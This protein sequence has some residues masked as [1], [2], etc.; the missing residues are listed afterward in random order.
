MG[1][2]F[3]L[4]SV[5]EIPRRLALDFGDF[6][7]TGMSF[8]SINGEFALVG[9]NANTSNLHIASPAADI[10]IRGRT[11]L[12]ARD[13]DQQ[14]VV[15][16]RVGGAL[17]VVGA[18]AG[19]PAGA[20]AGLAVQTLFNKAINQVT[21]ARY[22]VTGSWEKPD[23]TLISREGGRTRPS[24]TPPAANDAGELHGPPVEAPAPQP[25]NE[26]R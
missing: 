7:R 20:A 6:F 25:G 26:R 2:L 5:R 23:I 22:H 21:T 4:F 13:Y 19:G 16:P 3:G 10:R 17:T 9:G 11:G 24:D 12:K 14:M 8:T 15:T 18:L 1:R